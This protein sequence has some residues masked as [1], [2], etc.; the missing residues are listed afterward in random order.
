MARGIQEVQRFQARAASAR[1]FVSEVVSSFPDTVYTV[2]DYS[3]AVLKTFNVYYGG[4]DLGTETFTISI[5]TKAG[6]TV[7]FATFD[8]A[9]LQWAEILTDAQE[10]NLGPGWA[11]ELDCTANVD[12]HVTIS[13]VEMRLPQ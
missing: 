10:L 4:S 11:I 6:V 12:A 2:P 9:N 7:T 13:G 8:L 5:I 1:V 3:E